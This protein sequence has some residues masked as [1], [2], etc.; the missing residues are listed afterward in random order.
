M[1][2][3]IDKD[4]DKFDFS[5]GKSNYFNVSDEISTSVVRN[6][7]EGDIRPI[8]NNNNDMIHEFGHLL[9]LSDKYGTDKNN[10]ETYRKALPEYMGNVMAEEAG[11]GIVEPTNVVDALHPVLSKPTN[12]KIY[13][14]NRYNSE[15]RRNKK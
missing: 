4:T 6:S 13:F 12:A 15:Y 8:I 3:K 10:P 14:L 2:Q 9:G 1:V 7:H 11:M 5:N